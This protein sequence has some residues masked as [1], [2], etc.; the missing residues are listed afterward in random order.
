M[1][2]VIPAYK[3]IPSMKRHALEKVAEFV[4]AARK[5]PQVPFVTEHV[6]HGGMYARTVRV[7][8]H[9]MLAGVLI[10]VPTILIVDGDIVMYTGEEVI[11]HTG[12]NVFPASASRQAAFL[13]LSE[14]R[15]TMMLATSL[16]SVR[17]IEKS[18]T[19]D[20]EM[21]PSLEN[22]SAHRI[23]ITGE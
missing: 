7:P 14:V 17:D 19:D 8:A 12:Y 4:T 20:Y 11:R 3:H 1:S 23:V 9:T 6:I 5:M 10:K 18:F 13:M 16:S 15:M 2:D 21:L 22:A